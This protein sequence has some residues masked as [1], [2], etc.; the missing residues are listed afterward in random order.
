MKRI[1]VL[2]VGYLMLGLGLLG[3]CGAALLGG[4]RSTAS[5]Q[6]AANP[7]FVRVLHASPFVGTADVFVDGAK[8]LSSFAFGAVTGY[9][10]VPAGPH[11]VQIALVGKGIG[12]AALTQ[13][14]T[15]SPGFAYTVAAIGT[16][17]SN[18]SLQVFVD[19]N[20]L[21]PG[22]A[23]LR[24]YQLSPDGGTV[25]VSAGGK[26]LLSG[27]GYQNAS[28]YAVVAAGSYTFNVDSPANNATLTTSAALA[29]NTVDSLF[30][31]GMFNGTP[32]SEL[33]SSQAQGLPGL[34]NTGSDPNAIS[35]IGSAQPFAPS[36][37]SWPL[38]IASLLIIGC[39]VYLR[40]VTAKR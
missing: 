6:P 1:S 2:G 26:T 13:V 20:L 12:A 19:D 30:V 33:V 36:P 23:K 17:A 39:G 18:L 9:A 3:I 5:A 40:R 14:L 35:Q 25:T 15:V 29:A 37:W 34:P 38:G 32:K 16:S 4:P 8:L 31:V 28:N 22:T 27:I 11:K 7:S 24:V 10:T 21:S